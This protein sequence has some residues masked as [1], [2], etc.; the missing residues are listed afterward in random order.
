MTEAPQLAWE[1]PVL[2]FT[3]EFQRY[4]GRS[5]AVSPDGQRMHVLRSDVRAVPTTI[6]IV[7][8]WRAR[9]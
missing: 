4:H 7:T 3:G 6:G 1:K 5:F 2:A 9:G 8:N